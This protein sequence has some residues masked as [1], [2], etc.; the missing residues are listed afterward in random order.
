LPA[1][2]AYHDGELIMLLEFETVVAGQLY[3][4]DAM[5]QPGV[6]L[7]KNFTYA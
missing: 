7:G 4:V 1:A 5:N 2:D 6:E 3:D